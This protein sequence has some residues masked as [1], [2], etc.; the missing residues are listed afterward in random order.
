MSPGVRR[1]R[2]ISAMF[3]WEAGRPAGGGPLI[4]RRRAR[5][6]S[7]M[8]AAAAAAAFGLAASGCVPVVIG[9]GAMAVNAATQERGIGGAVGDAEIQASINHFWLQHDERLLSR[10]DMTVDEGR[11]LLT[12]RA[13]DEQMRADAVRLAWQASRVQEV[14]NE[15]EIDPTDSLQQRASDRWIA[16]RLRTAL[17]TDGGI[18]QNNYSIVVV[19]GSVYLLGRASGQAELDRALGHA[20]GIPDVRRVVSYVR[21]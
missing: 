15:I 10:L 3:A 11:V 6:A 13:L 12:G 1:P 5:V 17:I 16:T 14:I 4:D 2:P 7:R 9:G 21:F 20:R 19:N 8:L 18:R